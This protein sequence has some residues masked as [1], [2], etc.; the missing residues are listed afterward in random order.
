MA[1]APNSIDFWRGLA[2][3]TIAIDHIPGNFYEGWTLRNFALSDASQIFVFLA[4][5]AVRLVLSG[6]KAQA[7][8]TAARMRLV[9]RAWTLYVAQALISAIALGILEAAAWWF[10]AA[11]IHDWLNAADFFG[12]PAGTTLGFL[13]LGTQLSYFNILPL[14]VALMLWAPAMAWLDARGPWLALGVS[15]AIYAVALAFRLNF[16]NWPGEGGWF[17]DPFAW[18]FIFT[19]GFALAGEAGLGGW[20][21]RHSRALTALAVPILVAGLLMVR[22]KWS[23]RLADLPEP[24]LFFIFSKTYLSPAL[25]LSMLA[26][27]A[28]TR[29]VFPLVARWA[30]PV[31][32]WA[33]LLG[34]NSLNVFCVGSVA[35]LLAQI[36]RY[37][38]GGGLAVDT[39]LVGASVALALF[40][41]WHT[42]WRASRSPS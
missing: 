14:Y 5:W 34:R 7:D 42:E 12:D 6:R 31:A 8:P 10:D 32:R 37:W 41:A 35:S 1:R 16:P 23:P 26:L 27:A 25:I 39:F 21:R 2:L 20:A 18:Q 29:W 38:T 36:A 19:L 28:T 15:A 3:V 9:R 4:G 11:F 33:S 22:F 17:L 13:S 24:R 30:G 40:T